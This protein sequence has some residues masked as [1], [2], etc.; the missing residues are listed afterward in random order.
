MNKTDRYS[1]IF[2]AFA[3]GYFIVHIIIALFKFFY[4]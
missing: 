1:Y 2:L 4:A 3:A